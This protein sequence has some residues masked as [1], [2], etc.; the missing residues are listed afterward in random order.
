M[1]TAHLDTREF[2]KAMKFYAE[3]LKKDP[4]YVVNRSMVN[5]LIKTIAATPKSTKEI[6]N[7]S[8]H[9]IGEK[10]VKTFRKKKSSGRRVYSGKTKTVPAFSSPL[11]YKILNK[12]F[13]GLKRGQGVKKFLGRRRAAIGYSKA[14]WWPAALAFDKLK[15]GLKSKGA[16]ASSK[17]FPKLI[18]RGAGGQEGYKST[19]TVMAASM[20][21]STVGRKALEVAFVA[22]AK[23]MRDYIAKKFKETARKVAKVL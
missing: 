4:Q 2:D 17:K 20:G 12:N 21:S 22:A 19:A 18:G 15:I 23:D 10:Q 16:S 11:I 9:L 13:K 6:V 5:V 1:I 8:L 3:R 7:K 14:A